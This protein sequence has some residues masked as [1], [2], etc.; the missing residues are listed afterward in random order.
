MDLTVLRETAALAR[1]NMSGDELEKTFPAF[2]QMLSFFAVMERDSDNTGEQTDFTDAKTAAAEG[3]LGP[4]GPVCRVPGYL[5]PDTASPPDE[6]LFESML[7]QAPE[8]DG[9]FIVIPNVL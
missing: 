2:E 6:D 5:R 9:R 8:R 4:V 3:N 1:I 7:S